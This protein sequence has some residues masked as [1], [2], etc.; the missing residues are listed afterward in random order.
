MKSPTRGGGHTKQTPKCSL[1]FLAETMSIY[2]VVKEVGEY[3]NYEKENLNYFDSKEDA[4]AFIRLQEKLNEIESVYSYRG[5][6]YLSIEVIEKGI[7]AEE[8]KKQRKEAKVILKQRILKKKDQ[9]Q[10]RIKENEV[11]LEAKKAEERREIYEFISWFDAGKEKD[12]FFNEKL[13]ARIRGI[14][15]TLT[16]YMENTDDKYV[17]YWVSKHPFCIT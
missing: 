9:E 4:E 8:S 3:S 16:N 5:A 7:T 1:L 12:P 11:R 2:L 14:K 13:S 10:Q 17:E 15:S 6:T